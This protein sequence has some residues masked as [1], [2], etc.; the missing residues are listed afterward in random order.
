MILADAALLRGINVGEVL[1]GR[2]SEARSR[3]CIRSLK[4]AGK[5]AT[6]F[7]YIRQ[8]EGPY[9]VELGSRWFH[10]FADHLSTKKD[11]GVV[12]LS[13]ISPSLFTEDVSI[14]AELKPYADRILGEI[15]HLTD[16]QLKTR[17]YLTEPMREALAA[18]RLGVSVLNRPLL[19]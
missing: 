8:K 9:C 13:W 6:N 19:P 17:V 11:R 14:D 18:E 5:R 10:R 16:S 3:K 15:E 12:Q 1:A 7:V 2:V 4:D